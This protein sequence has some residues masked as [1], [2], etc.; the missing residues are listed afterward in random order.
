MPV[1]KRRQSLVLV[2]GLGAQQPG[3]RPM[4][5]FDLG[6]HPQ[7]AAAGQRRPGRKEAAEAPGARV[8]QPAVVVAHRHRHVGLLGGDPEV[9][10]Q[11]A[12]RRVRAVV[13]H[14]KRGV[15]ADD[16]PV[17]P[18]EVVGM[19]VPADPGVRFEQGDAIACR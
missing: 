15:D 2:G 12:Q 13:V 7:V 10:E 17:A 4:E 16:V 19:R 14:Q 1:E 3:R 18:V 9:V 6:Q 5:P 8:L 11:P